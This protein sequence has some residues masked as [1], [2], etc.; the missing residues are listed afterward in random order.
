[1]FCLF[2]NIHLI[3][4]WFNLTWGVYKYAPGHRFWQL[5]YDDR[6]ALMR[7]VVPKHNLRTWRLS[8]TILYL[9]KDDGDKVTHCCFKLWSFMDLT[10]PVTLNGASYL[11][12]DTQYAERMPSSHSADVRPSLS[13]YAISAWH[14]SIRHCVTARCLHSDTDITLQWVGVEQASVHASPAYC[15]EC[16]LSLVWAMMAVKSPSQSFL[17]VFFFCFSPRVPEDCF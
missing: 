4:L 12:S 6:F 11:L 14:Q 1:M 17:C 3:F 16:N 2:C 5:L 13:V 9:K 10:N 7:G 15:C 8:S